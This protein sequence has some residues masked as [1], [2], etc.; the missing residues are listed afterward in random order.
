MNK[1][2]SIKEIKTIIFDWDGT[3]HESMHI[4]KPA[5]L[6]AHTYLENHGYCPKK[7]WSDDEIKRYLG[8][9]PKEMW[10]SF[11][12]KLPDEVIQIVS[13]MISAHMSQAIKQGKAR[14]YD[15]AIDVLKTLKEKGYHL[16]YLSNSKTYYMIAMDEA[17]GL[18]RYFD[19]IIASEMYAYLPKK[20]ILNRIK[21]TLPLTW[22]VVGDR[23][24]DIEAGMHHDAITV[25]CDYGYGTPDELKDADYHINDIRKLL[26]IIL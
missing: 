17:F 8:M 23:N 5:F 2:K 20:D 10:A 19:L 3:L 22:M 13:P 15:G 4:Y 16:V 14:L 7:T 12:P 11:E 25:A 21:N 18:G 24:V 9:N 1:T 26:Q 6:E